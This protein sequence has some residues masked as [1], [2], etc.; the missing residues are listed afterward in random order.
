MGALSNARARPGKE[1]ASGPS[2]TP[3]PLHSG[4]AARA[5]WGPRQRKPGG[6]V[7]GAGCFRVGAA[8]RLQG[9]RQ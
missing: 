3:P 2:T 6:G 1:E 4:L 9:E 8:K 5:L 7:P